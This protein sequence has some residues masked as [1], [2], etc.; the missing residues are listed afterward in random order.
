M[1]ASG[2]APTT[3]GTD[4]EEEIDIA[5]VLPDLPPSQR[6]SID[7]IGV[8]GTDDGDLGLD[9][10]GATSG[11]YLDHLM[12]QIKAPIA[13]RWASIALRRSLLSRVKTPVDVNG[14][15]F[16]A[17]RAMLLLRMGE[18]WSA[19][20]LV[21]AVDA[22]RSTAMLREVGLQAALANA[23]PGAMCPMV[24][25]TP[26][27]VR[28]NH[29]RMARAVCFALTSEPSQA[30]AMID[31][32]RDSG[33]TATIDAILAEKV[34]GAG[35]NSRRSVNILWED[36]K[37]LTTWRYGMATSVAVPV[38]EALM[39]TAG[40]QVRAWRA[41]ASLLPAASRVGD[42]E[43][44]AALGVYSSS[45]LVQA[46]ADAADA[47]DPGEARGAGFTQL[48]DAYSAPTFDARLSA[49]AQF[50]KSSDPVTRYARLIATARAA[51]D[52][53]AT[54]DTS[55]SADMLIASMLSAGLDM[56]AVRWAKFAGNGSLGQ[57]LLAVG[58]PNT[59]INF[60]GGDVKGFGEGESGKRA[61]F[62]LAG[63]AGLERMSASD[64]A[65]AAESLEVP[66]SQTDSWT[67]ALDRAVA[68]GEKA[69][70]T[71]LVALGLQGQNWS[72]VSAQRLYRA[73]SAMHRVGMD[74][75]AR[76]IAAEALMRS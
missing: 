48:R 40:P 11:R 68:G 69:T 27:T 30:S 73:V 76:M 65:S 21:Q 22:D 42:A 28:D 39:K 3:E 50:W 31:S 67:K 7:Q 26:T 46:Y 59:V 56:Q 66:I 35:G 70:V 47:T 49:M 14:A 23:D 43:V 45:A 71:L 10:Y 52:I 8:L 4:G 55:G 38:P 15:D 29:W 17:Y 64:A 2:V 6:R 53:Q 33:K 9:A 18:A 62:L 75:E 63:L 58:A 16:A 61:Q 51:N 1:A 20:Q 13:S 24:D 37:S 72:Q 44:A 19:R 41:T 74:G 57:A 54:S 32:V 5:A 34:I 36:V 12:Q 25:Y 60:D